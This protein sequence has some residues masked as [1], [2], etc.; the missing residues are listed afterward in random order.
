MP[1]LIISLA[2]PRTESSGE[3]VIGNEVM[4]SFTLTSFGFKPLATIFVSRSHPVTIPI[5]FPFSV[6]G[7]PS[8]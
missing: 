4:K 5:G 7:K 1:C 3:H 8:T 2:T 6:T